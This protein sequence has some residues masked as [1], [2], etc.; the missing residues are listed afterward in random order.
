MKTATKSR[1]GTDFSWKPLIVI[2]EVVPSATFLEGKDA[3]A[4]LKEY[5]ARVE[6]D[7]D[8]NKNL[9]VLAYRNG[10]VQGSNPFAVALTDQMLREQG[11]R[12]ATMAD[13]ER[14]LQTRA[15]NLR[16]QYEDTGL[17]LRSVDN[18]NEY[19][20]GN[21]AE[22]LKARGQTVGK[23]SVVIPLRGLNVVGDDASD[24]GLAFQL[25]DETQ[26]I[27]A[28]L[29]AEKYNGKRFK[30]LDENGMPIFDDEG[31]R[32]NYTRGSGLS[33]LGLY[34]GLVLGSLWGRLDY[35]NPDGRVV[36]VS[37]EATR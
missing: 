22:Q 28:P 9:R 1:I 5:D 17:V 8:N 16:N 29:L 13:L 18:P 32:V 35:S 31:N 21:L 27:E 11:I 12:V 10:V 26:I 4:F 25:T 30:R 2:P 33:R 23:N 37:G 15:L 19:L 7:Y 20:A 6:A 3:E 36:L 24:Y 34:G 14:A